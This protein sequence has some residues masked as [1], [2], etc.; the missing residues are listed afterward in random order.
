MAMLKS[1]ER[2]PPGGFTFYEPA[3]KWR[4]P[5]FASFSTVVQQLIY[6]RHA[7]PFL[8]KDKA[9]DYNTV[10]NEV[11]QF[12]AAKCKA[13]GYTD[14]IYEVAEADPAPKT[15]APLKRVQRLVAGAVTVA[16]FF[17]SKEDAVPRPVADAR[18]AICAFCPKNLPGSFE[19]FFTVPV[20][21][22]LRS[23]LEKLKELDL[24]TPYDEK[25]NVCDVCLC[26]M[27]LKVHFPLDLLL[28]RMPSDVL[29]ELKA[30][31]PPCWIITEINATSNQRG[32]SPVNQGL[33]QQP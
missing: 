1:R 6:H 12:T 29:E 17:K 7:N 16:E 31:V 3:T 25:L 26:P 21:Q 9:T 19:S 4:P 5:D 33:V 10:A 22:A 30:V 32:A 28:K 23:S 14:W 8:L 2:F 11:D 24:S 13:M 27:K 20:S 15:I 18:G